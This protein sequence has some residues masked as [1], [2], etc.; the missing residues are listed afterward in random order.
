VKDNEITAKKEK[1][2]VKPSPSPFSGA[3]AAGGEKP[4]PKPKPKPKLAPK[5]KPKPEAVSG[6]GSSGSEGS[7]STSETD[8]GAVGDHKVDVCDCN[9]YDDQLCSSCIKNTDSSCSSTSCAKK[10]CS[11]DSYKYSQEGVSYKQ[12][13]G[14]MQKDGDTNASG[15]DNG[16]S[17]AQE[18]V[19]GGARVGGTTATLTFFLAAAAALGS[20]IAAVVFSRR[21]RL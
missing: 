12:K 3:V 11:Y 20:T 15:G 14:G 5:P 6:G 2:T 4:K 19:F 13:D 9:Q 18:S 7:S 16:T 17:Y 1:A 8:Q 10:C 21:V